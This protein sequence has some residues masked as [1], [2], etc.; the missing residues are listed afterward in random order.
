MFNFLRASIILIAV[1]SLAFGCSQRQ[2]QT[3]VNTTY[4]IPAGDYQQITVQM[5]KGDRIDIEVSVASDDIALSV[6]APTG[7]S[8]LSLSRISSD[9]FSVSALDY[10]KNETYYIF[11]DNSY[12]TQTEKDV[13]LLVTLH[14]GK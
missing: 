2:V 5:T 10:I 4:H 7:E 13:T 8:L 12:S 3:L 11:L 14:S 1:S 9:K 6:V